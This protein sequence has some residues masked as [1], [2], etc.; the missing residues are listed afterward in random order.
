[1]SRQLLVLVMMLF[2]SV[3]SRAQVKPA[4]DLDCSNDSGTCHLQRAQ[5][6]LSGDEGDSLGC[7]RGLAENDAKL[8][9]DDRLR[10]SI[11]ELDEAISAG[12]L[13]LTNLTTAKF[14]K[15]AALVV[16]GGKQLALGDPAGAEHRFSD[17]A[18]IYMSFLNASTTNPTP[19][20]LSRIAVGLFRCGRPVQ[21]FE[22]IDHLQSHSSDREYLTAEA[23]MAIGQR[24]LAASAYEDWIS[25]GCV[26]RLSMLADDEFGERWLFLPL[27][28]PRE[29]TKCEQMPTE[30][31]SRLSTLH[32]EYGHPANIPQRSFPS[33]PFPARTQ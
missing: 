10:R 30:L 20:L 32:T 1:M 18:L 16:L 7:N 14:D 26:S 3:P 21:A 12:D 11:V 31:R 15:A 4:C 28:T 9:Q 19:E 13:S 6:L 8:S 24:K 27:R 23:L 25:S 22:A 5:V 2:L 17:A 33:E 29:Q